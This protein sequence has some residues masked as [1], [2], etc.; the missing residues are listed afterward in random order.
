MFEF[1]LKV[2]DQQVVTILR[3]L[4]NISQLTGEIADNENNVK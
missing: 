3:S 4:P 1:F 2:I